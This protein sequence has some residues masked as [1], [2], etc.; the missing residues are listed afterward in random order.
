MAVVQFE[1][2]SPIPIRCHPERSR[3]SGGVK[4][5]PLIDFIVRSK[6]HHHLF[7][8]TMRSVDAICRQPIL[9]IDP[10]PPWKEIAGASSD[11]VPSS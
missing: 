2:S 11:Q 5:L 7:F 4:D 6:L 9:Q 10:T 8:C 1:L 3:F